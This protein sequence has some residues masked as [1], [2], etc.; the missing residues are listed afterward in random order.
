MTP[1]TYG[2]RRGTLGLCTIGQVAPLRPPRVAT[3]TELKM[4]SLERRRE[5][6]LI[7]YTWR[8]LEA[9]V[10]NIGK[11]IKQTQHIRRGR[12][13]VIPKVNTRTPNRIQNLREASFTVHGPRLFNTLP[14]M[15]RNL[16]CCSVDT[17]KKKLDRHLALVPDQP[18]IQGYTAQRRADSNSLLDMSGLALHENSQEGRDLDKNISLTRGGHPWPPW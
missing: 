14:A 11:G 13:C 1:I 4:Y 12:L 17:F 8:I 16:T 7:I 2:E 9:Q 5:R 6:Y 18:Q 10:P 3:V 15:I